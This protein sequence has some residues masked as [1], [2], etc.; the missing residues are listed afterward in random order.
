[1]RC[2]IALTF[3]LRAEGRAWHTNGL[4]RCFRRRPPAALSAPTR[5]LG[6]LPFANLWSVSR[7]SLQY[8]HSGSEQYGDAS[9]SG[10]S[11]EAFAKN[12]LIGHAAILPPFKFSFL[13]PTCR[14]RK[15][16]NFCYENRTRR[17]SSSTMRVSS[18]S[19]SLWPSLPP[20]AKICATNQTDERFGRGDLGA[21][22]SGTTSGVT[23][24]LHS[25]TPECL[26][27]QSPDRGSL[28]RT[29]H[30]RPLTYVSVPSAPLPHGESPS[31]IGCRAYLN[32]CVTRGS[33]AF[34]WKQRRKR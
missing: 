6:A 3:Q 22:K 33:S 7:N 25:G 16:Y 34:T 10:D 28:Q 1:M 5:R 14:S 4:Q 29:R 23:V 30:A 32:F 21:P 17:W 20:G 18:S 31:V 13:P 24:G 19:H 12:G 9:S 27:G 2:H 15:K 11:S 26:S 8:S